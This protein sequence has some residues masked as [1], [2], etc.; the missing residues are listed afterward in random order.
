MGVD[1]TTV[2]DGICV[3]D[4]CDP[5]GS[6][7]SCIASASATARYQ[8]LFGSAVGLTRCVR[9]RTV[10]MWHW[11]DFVAQRVGQLLVRLQARRAYASEAALTKFND[12]T[13]YKVVLVCCC[14]RACCLPSVRHVGR[15]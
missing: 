8:T 14:G 13:F 12:E 9:R 4:V 15:P 3:F 7:R 1:A 10:G 6:S 5:A 2:F 11:Q